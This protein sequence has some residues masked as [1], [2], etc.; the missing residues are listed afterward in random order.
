MTN[1]FRSS[2][3]FGD[4]QTWARVAQIRIAGRDDVLRI[5]A[6][7]AAVGR[8]GVAVLQAEVHEPV[9]AERQSGIPGDRERLPPAA[10]PVAGMLDVADDAIPAGGQATRVRIAVSACAELQAAAR[11]GILELEVHD[12]GNGIRAILRRCAVAQ[13][14]GLPNRNRG[15]DGE[16]RPLRAVRNAVA[17]PGDDRRA[18]AALAVDQDQRVIGRQIAQVHWPDDGPRVTNRLNANVE[19]GDDGPQLL[20]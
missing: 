19:R 13:H 6:L 15:D 18:V 8:P 9:P 10:Y 1:S 12:A 3:S 20:S 7:N 2:S 17:E 4:P 5:R 14:L 11:T 16:I